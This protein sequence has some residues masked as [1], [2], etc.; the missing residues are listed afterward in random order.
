M[1]LP[2]I[3]GGENI[4]LLSFSSEKAFNESDLRPLENVS[5][6]LT[7]LIKRK[8][9]DETI[10]SGL[11]LEKTVS[12]VS[13]RFVAFSDL[14]EA[15]NSTL[16]DI[17]RL[18]KAGHAYL[19]QFSADGKTVSNTHEWC[20]EGVSPQLDNLQDLPVEFIYWW[21]KKLRSG[22]PIHITDV[23]N[24]PPEAAAEKVDL[25]AR[26][27]RSLLVMPLLTKGGNLTGFICFDNVKD[28]VG[29][30]N[31]DL[32]ILNKLLTLIIMKLK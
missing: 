32:S 11:L 16:E 17:G 20:A 7:A 29:L 5:I 15:I 14:D 4:G 10:K 18:C 12:K 1:L 31:C 23:A 27:S 28:T 24:L 6:K 25:E 26:G 13:S 30:R 8:Q 19:F 9:D 3:S 22:E 21:M 2:L